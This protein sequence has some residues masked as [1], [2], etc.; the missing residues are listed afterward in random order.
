MEDNVSKIKEKLHVAD[1][2]RA[3]IP[4]IPAGRN[5]KANCPFHK[6]KTPS[7]MV[8]PD[9]EMWY[10]FGCAEGGDIFKFVMKYENLEFFEALKILGEKAGVELHLSGSS[11]EAFKEIYD[12]NRLAKD[13]FVSNFWTAQSAHREAAA[14]YLKERGL[15]EETIREFEIGLAPTA[16]DS[17]LRHLIAKKKSMGDIERAGMVFKSERGTYWDRFRGRLMFP[18][19]NA[20]GK[21]IG[22]TGRVL[23]SEV[24]ATGFD[25]AKY[26]N[27]PETPIFHKSKLLYGFH[28]SKNHIRDAK[29]AIV[30]EGQM[31][32]LMSWQ[33]GVR[34]VVA[35]SGTALTEEHLQNLRRLAD[36]LLLCFDSDEAGQ[37]A[38]ERSIDLANALDFNVKLIKITGGAKDPA[39]VVASSP[40]QLGDFIKNAGSAMHWYFDRYLS[41]KSEISEKKRGAESALGKIKRLG[42]PIVREHY[43][44]ELSLRTG[45]S[46]AALEEQMRFM[47]VEA[48]APKFSKNDLPPLKVAG[49]VTKDRKSRLEKIS[50]RIV[51]LVCAEPALGQTVAPAADFLAEKYRLLWKYLE[52]G[53][54]K[55]VPPELSA[56]ADFVVLG[57]SFITNNPADELN[58]LVKELKLENLKNRREELRMKIAQMEQGDDVVALAETLK[59]FDQISKELHN[60]A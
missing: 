58:D 43:L 35:S 41:G 51:S 59:I 44:R 15:K 48:L 40:G 46:M 25:S 39:D 14:K 47:K 28:K 17:L 38:A 60:T 56:E 30:V 49:A 27:S 3:Y 32:F 4:L 55:N 11:G 18:L 9:R 45:F 36:H 33:D 24:L 31:D 7:F 12:I 29:A 42:S 34:N 20:F 26:V 10:C 22:F 54:F 21:V 37:N 19:Y 1:V 13:F 2:I 57:A 53:V 52:A 6:E 8:S 5:L 23:P 50:E 16:T